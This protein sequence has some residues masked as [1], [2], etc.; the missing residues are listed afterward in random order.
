[1][2]GCPFSDGFSPFSNSGSLNSLKNSNSSKEFNSS[3]NALALKDDNRYAEGVN[4]GD[5]HFL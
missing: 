4:E 1:M 5:A 2:Q 3:E